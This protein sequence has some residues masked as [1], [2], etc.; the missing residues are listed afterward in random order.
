M[1]VSIC[2]VISCSTIEKQK[3]EIYH[4]S[5]GFS[6]DMPSDWQA[7]SQ[8]II[9]N[10]LDLNDGGYF[11]GVDKDL[12]EET[13]KMLN[14]EEYECYFKQYKSASG[15]IFMYEETLFIPQRPTHKNFIERFCKE[16]PASLSQ[17]FGKTV[18]IYEC[19]FKKVAGTDS[20]YLVH[21]GIVDET[22]QIQYYI[23]KSQS[24]CIVILANCEKEDHGIFR[25]EID[26]IM[27]SFAFY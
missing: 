25:K 11:N 3:T 17:D 18:K 5:F 26:N 14:T 7:L 24:I 23:P 2:I 22:I 16:V 21:D 8:E 15:I 1:L 19:K 13:K 6:I 27:N 9:K 20:L 4:S 10:N 12:I